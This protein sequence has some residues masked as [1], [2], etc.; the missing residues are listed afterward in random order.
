MSTE[1]ICSLSQGITG[2]I[3]PLCKS[4]TL[5]QCIANFH[6]YSVIKKLYTLLYKFCKFNSPSDLFGASRKIWQTN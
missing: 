1:I 2:G 3:Y 5:E 6:V 4:Y